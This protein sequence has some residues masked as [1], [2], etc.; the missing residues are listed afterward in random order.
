MPKR[1]SVS[2]GPY[3]PRRRTSAPKRRRPYY[4]NRRLG[5][6]RGRGAYAAPKSA[7]I[8][9]DLGGY[10]GSA[11]GL[12]PGGKAFSGLASMAGAKIGGFLGNKL[13]KYMGWGSY[14]V[15]SNSLM[16]PEG[17]S[18]AQ[19][20]TDG[21][22]VRIAHRE[23]ID[24][25][26]APGDGSATARTFQLNPG[27]STV[28]PW[29]YLQALSY[30]KYKVLGAIYEF[31]STTGNFSTATTANPNVG[32]VV[33]STNYNAADPPFPTRIA[34][35][36]TQYCSS[37]KPST[38]FVH[39]VECDPALQAQENLYI[40]EGGVPR[41]QMSINEANWCQTTVATY[42]TQSTAGNVQYQV[43]SLY[44]TYDILL[45]QPVDRTASVTKTSAFNNANA[46][47]EPYPLG[48]T[49]Y[50]VANPNNSLPCVITGYPGWT[51][52]FNG[53][54]ITLPESAQGAFLITWQCYGSPV[55]VPIS[56]PT[57]GFLFNCATLYD[58]DSNN[59]NLS[60]GAP[61]TGASSIL[62]TVVYGIRVTGPRPSLRFT[63]GTIP[64]GGNMRLIVTQIDA[65]LEGLMPP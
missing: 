25:I 21:N 20:H 5:A 9:A 8:G 26:Y 29:L 3:R 61:A 30:Q 55:G 65:D 42:A 51:G 39:I 27:N 19:M 38:S 49:R 46:V 54:L 16:V 34:M 47:N 48:D 1:R 24:D 28:F 35:E 60:Y 44:I 45:I 7:A 31:K 4:S 53:N 57:F 36:N 63:G 56:L 41:S 23:F 12:L 2:R 52:G 43:G 64:D 59:N 58:Y 15:R 37:A 17:N 33:I 13:G 62:A 32:E 40:V 11:V 10:L 14:K 22:Y 6:Y 18:P 50:A